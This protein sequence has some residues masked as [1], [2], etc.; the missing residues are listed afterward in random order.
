LATASR[1]IYAF[2]VIS[3]AMA[4]DYRYFVYIMTNRSRT[5]YT[6]ITNNLEI[7][8]LQHKSGECEGFT[9]RYKVDRLVYFEEWQDVNKA[10]SREKQTKRW[11]RVKK[12]ALI[13]SINPTWRDLSEDWGKP[14]EPIVRKTNA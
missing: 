5:L 6:G 3:T 12:V 13:V 10:I 8:V 2:L 4:R 14:I 7:R 11:R 1:G 9:T